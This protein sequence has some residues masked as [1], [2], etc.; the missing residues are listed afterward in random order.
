MGKIRILLI[1]K[2]D[3]LALTCPEFMSD[4]ADAV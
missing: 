3:R 1:K 4:R 2:C